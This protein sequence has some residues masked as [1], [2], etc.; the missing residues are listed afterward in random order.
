VAWVIGQE[1]VITEEK[2]GWEQSGMRGID[3]KQIRS[4]GM[5]RPS[6]AGRP[7]GEACV[8]ALGA[9]GSLRQGAQG[10][11]AG[12][13]SGCEV[14]G[15]AVIVRAPCPWYSLRRAF[16]SGARPQQAGCSIWRSAAE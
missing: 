12:A 7:G 14:I 11:C 10:S 6:C 5:E 1:G 8:S 2:S 13:T 3:A 4:G 16:P 15:A 9:M